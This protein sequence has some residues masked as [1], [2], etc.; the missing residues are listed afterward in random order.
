MERNMQ[1]L[2]KRKTKR[3]YFTLL[4]ISAIVY[5]FLAVI[6]RYFAPLIVAFL[7]LAA[8]E[9]GLSKWSSKLKIGRKPVAYIFLVFIIASVALC[10]WF[11][12][13]PYLQGCDFSWCY[14]LLDH[15]WIIKAVTYMQEHGMVPVAEWSQTAIRISS[16]VLFN[17]GAYGLSVFLLAGVF[18]KMKNKMEQQSE[19]RLL[20]GV[21]KDVIDY[22]KAYLKTQGKL[23]VIIC[24][25]CIPGLMLSGIQ[26]GWLLGIL[27]GI[28]DF[29]PVFG[30][31]IVLV[32]TALWQ[33]LEKDY[34]AGAVCSG[35]FL[36]CAVLREILE[37]KFLGKAI[38][39]P[40][41]GIWI[42]IYAGIQLF[43]TSGIFKGPIGYLLIC[44]IY[45][46]IR[47]QDRP[48]EEENVHFS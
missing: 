25:I 15:P 17:V 20:L 19:G 39:L 43:G 33:F 37:P 34:L 44:T 14:E 27:A 29:F 32:P 41:I 45:R 5:F 18:A 36:V 10:V 6:W 40:S 28:L 30:T 48:S 23:F 1:E 8:V 38:K 11:G 26:G 13:I 47:C 9:P 2:N 46:R 16:K 35:L 3:P 31:G 42:S 22:G 7:I 21:S 24:L 4:L 12:L